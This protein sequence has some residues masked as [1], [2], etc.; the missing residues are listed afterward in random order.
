MQVTEG[1]V[2]GVKLRMLARVL[3]ALVAAEWGWSSLD[4]ARPGPAAAALGCLVKVP[5]ARARLAAQ[6]GAEEALVVK[7]DLIEMMAA[8]KPVDQ[9]QG[10]CLAVVPGE[11][12]FLTPPPVRELPAQSASSGPAQLVYSHPLTLAHHKEKTTCLQKLKTVW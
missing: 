9:G 2:V 8:T 11:Q 3:G 1:L 5:M 6:Q 12:F 10:V 4:Q 7:P